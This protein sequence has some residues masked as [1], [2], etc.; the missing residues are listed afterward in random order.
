METSK[1]HPKSNTRNT[2]RLPL[3]TKGALIRG[4]HRLVDILLGVDPRAVLNNSPPLPKIPDPAASLQKAANAMKAEALGSQGKRIDYAALASSAAYKAFQRY[5]RS[6]PNCE[7]AELGGPR[8]KM[9]FWLN[10]YNALIMDAVIAFRVRDSVLEDLG[11]FRRAAYDVGGI[12]FSADDIE[13][14]ILRGN[15]RHP[16]LPL[17]P[18]GPDDPRMALV[19]EEPDARI[20]FAL[21][22]GARSCPPIAFYDGED[23]DAQLDLAASNFIRQE[24]VRYDRETNTLWLSKIF[25]WY[26]RDFGGKEGLAGF[27]SRYA[28]DPALKHALTAGGLSFR[29]QTYDWSVNALA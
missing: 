5:S 28:A 1:L 16:L 22:C 8:Q 9:A 10:L 29:Y 12:R 3:R 14:G 24:G 18:F 23:L 6:L 7:L 21:V 25:R 26:Q 13:H 19:I 11:F 2:D 4:A 15:R 20:H 27:I 17:P